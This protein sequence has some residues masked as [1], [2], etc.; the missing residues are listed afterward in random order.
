MIKE[1]K[2]NKKAGY[3]RLTFNSKL[4]RNTVETLFTMLG[5]NTDPWTMGKTKSTKSVYIP[6]HQKKEV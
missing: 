4:A 5:I 2:A 3:V 6:Y 1:I